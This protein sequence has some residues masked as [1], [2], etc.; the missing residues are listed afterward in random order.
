MA[1]ASLPGSRPSVH[2]HPQQAAQLPSRV[3][4]ELRRLEGRIR[5]LSVLSGLAIAIVAMV[6][7]A[8]VAFALD[9]WLDLSAASRWVALGT[10]IAT[11]VGLGLFGLRRLLFRVPLPELAAAVEEKHPEFG[12]RLLSLVEFSQA[13]VEE[14]DKGSVMMRALLERETLKLVTP[15]DFTDVVDHQRASW[16]AIAACVAMVMLLVPFLIWKDSYRLLWARLLTPWNNFDRPSNLFFEIPNGDRVVPRGEDAK[17]LAIANWRNQQPEPIQEVRLNWAFDGASS[18]NRRMAWDEAANAYSMS[19]SAVQ[20]GFRYSVSSPG[21][22]SREYQIRVEDR[23]AITSLNIDVQ[24]PAYTGLPAEQ[25]TAAVL[26]ILA[27]EHSQVSMQLSLNKPVQHL[28]LV[29]LDLES[30]NRADVGRAAQA[31]DDAPEG[32]VLAPG[33]APLVIPAHLT[34][35]FPGW[36]IRAIES[37]VLGADKKSAAFAFAADRP[38]RFVLHAI[39]EFGL[40]NAKE[41]IRSIDLRTDQPP[42]VDFADVNDQGTAKPDEIIE[43]P[44]YAT[45]DVGLAALELHIKSFPEGKSLKVISVAAERLGTKELAEG[46]AVNLAEFGLLAE[47]V[48]SLRARAADERAVPGPNETWTHERLVRIKSD[49]LPYGFEAIAAEREEW[50]ALL[51]QLRNEVIANRTEVQDMQRSVEQAK[52]E[53]KPFDRDS[54]VPRLAEVQLDIADKA[55]Q[56]AALLEDH[57]LFEKLA[58]V[59]KQVSMDDALPAAEKTGQVPQT[60]DLAAKDEA[61]KQATTELNE[62]EAKLTGLQAKFDQQ[63]ALER[64]LFELQRLANRTEQLAKDT[65]TYEDQRD[66]AQTPEAERT[67]DSPQALTPEERQKQKDQL[68]NRH[69][70]LSQDLN[71]LLEKRPELLTAA[72]EAL[73]KQLQELFDQAAELANREDKLGAALAKEAQKAAEQLSPQQQKQQALQQKAEAL[74][75]EQELQQDQKIAK[76]LDLKEF[77]K[78]LDEMRSGDAEL[79]AEAQRQAAEDLEKLADALERNA[80]LPAD[81]QAAAKELANRERQLKD[82]LQQLTQ[83]EH[84]SR[85][86]RQQAEQQKKPLTAQQQQSEEQLADQRRDLALEQ[87]A[88]QT[89]A[90][91]LDVPRPARDSQ[92]DAVRNGQDAVQQL[93]KDEPQQKPD[94]AQRATEAADRAANDLE[95]LAQQI[96]SPEERQQRALNEVRGIHDEQKNLARQ[97]EELRRQQAEGKPLDQFAE[98]LKQQDAKQMELAQRLA[99]VETLATAPAQQAAQEAQQQLALEKMAAAATDLQKQNLANTDATQAQA[100]QAL[101]DLRKQLEAQPTAAQALA[102]ATAKQAELSQASEQANKA[103]DQRQAQLHQQKDQQRQLAQSLDPVET[104]VAP[105]LKEAAKQAAHQAADALDR[106][107]NDE[108]QFPAA[109]DALARSEEALK[110]L[111]N[112]LKP[113]MQSPGEAAQALA[114]EQK[115]AAESSQQAAAA[116]QAPTPHAAAQ[117]L[118][119]LRERQQ[120]L[121]DLRGTEASQPE[122]QGAKKALAEAAKAQQQVEQLAKQQPAP[123]EGA[124]EPAAPTPELQQAMQQAAQQQQAAADALAKLSEK[125]QPADAQQVMQAAAGQDQENSVAA[126]EPRIAELRALA[127]KAEEL[128]AKQD[129]LQKLAAEELAKNAENPEAQKQALQALRGPQQQLNQAVRELPKGAAPLARAEAEQAADSADRAMELNQGEQATQAQSDAGDALRQLARQAERQADALAKQTGKQLAQEKETR[130]KEQGASDQEQAAEGQAK[131]GGEP[132]QALAQRARELAAEQRALAE[133]TS[134]AGDPNAKQLAMNEAGNAQPGQPLEGQPQ[135][136]Q[137]QPGQPQPGQPQPS[138]PQE[139]QPQ[140]GQPKA[141]QP[142]PRQPPQNQQSKQQ[143]SEAVA[144]ALKEQQKIALA[145]KDLALSSQFQSGADSQATQ[146]ADQFAKQAQAASQ[147]LAVGAVDSAAESGKT[148]AQQGELAAQELRQ[149]PQSQ[150]GANEEMAE[151]SEKL[152][153]RQARLS[154]RLAELGQTP[155]ARREAQQQA[156]EQLQQETEQLTQKLSEVADSFGMQPLQQ[157]SKAQEAEASESSAQQAQ[158]AMQSAKQNLQQSNPQKAAQQA[159]EAAQAL[160]DAGKLAQATGQPGQDGQGKPGEGQPGQSQS[161]IPSDGALSVAQAAQQLNKIGE[162]LAKDE[163]QPDPNGEPGQKPGEGNPGEGNQEGESG[164]GEQ[165]AQDGPPQA[166][167]ESSN[168]PPG[169]KPKASQNLKQTAANLRQAMEQFGLPQGQPGKPGNKNGKPNSPQNAKSTQEGENTSDFGNT[170]EARIVEMENHLKGLST[171]NWGELPGTLKTEILQAARKKPDGDYA[172]LIRRYFDEISRTQQPDL[173]GTKVPAAQGAKP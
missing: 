87:A 61:L 163:G 83:K 52:N 144:K 114:Q 123:A 55:M 150:G 137:P 16:R 86:A 142:Q 130:D 79:A 121:G 51:E 40:D 39:D 105:D 156:Q 88:L 9:Y 25:Y 24:P 120:E 45:D 115:A 47:D 31:A 34:G 69:Q 32:L 157:Q 155:A 58:P 110:D 76:P 37:G 165:Q 151:S 97:S 104:P 65:E 89:A 99:D 116:P 30:V 149:L 138:Q 49:S 147:E 82:Q 59:L 172:K 159:G 23:P 27:F 66:A 119:D 136:G 14:K 72:Q 68:L 84:E 85:Q 21:A 63:A 107:A 148:A 56:L 145:A 98:A 143:L 152:A 158:Q 112:A 20:Q 29:W 62:A 44:I 46:F 134:A 101:A 80:D 28:D 7:V 132:L 1:Q 135:P 19:L 10:L 167:P 48:I 100:E 106:A 53:N 161:P 35:K 108:K 33:G 126:T 139:G 128:A 160:R 169:G 64:D 78:V 146:A 125:L 170:D 94:T 90:A 17:L 2:L 60:P 74:A 11:G 133:E 168:P 6:I 41:P 102:Q 50:K 67:P 122:K 8:G 81:P 15:A 164:E 42:A 127:D 91:Q 171:R 70:S 141:G 77:D 95:R 73:L 5:S 131:Q 57:P 166:G 140:G 173:P 54:Q 4:E 75:A 129:E 117:A 154:E 111:S 13:G 92:K 18:E 93:L 43:V 153:E 38:G 36:V 124:T 3:T 71:Q 109:Q 113:E 103:G 12:E 26:E 162:Q 96:G 22:K 118:D